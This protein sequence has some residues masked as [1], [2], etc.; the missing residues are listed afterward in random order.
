VAIDFVSPENIEQCKK[1]TK[2][3]QEHHGK[4]WKE[5]VLQLKT[6]MWLYIL[7]KS[8]PGASAP[9]LPGVLATY[10]FERGSLGCRAAIPYYINGYPNPSKDNTSSDG[11]LT[12]T[13]MWWASRMI[14]RNVPA[15]R[16]PED[17]L[18]GGLMF[19]RRTSCKRTLT[20]AQCEVISVGEYAYAMLAPVPINSTVNFW[21]KNSRGQTLF[22]EAVRPWRTS[23]IVDTRVSGLSPYGVL[24]SAVD[25]IPD[26]LQVAGFWHAGVVVWRFKWAPMQLHYMRIQA[27]NICALSTTGVDGRFG[28]RRAT[29]R[30]VIDPQIWRSCQNPERWARE[31]GDI[32]IKFYG[33]KE[34]G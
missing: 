13:P 12:C 14:L 19:A 1:V 18:Y 29:L 10:E 3:F 27:R 8:A 24:P 25:H 33:G 32:C 31:C 2:E 16:R 26:L 34:N 23:E 9:C 4:A 15:Q 21:D 17:T 5:D 20:S 11:S 22:R 30:I 28:L 6:M 7:N